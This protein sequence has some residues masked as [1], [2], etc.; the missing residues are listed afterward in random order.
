[1][2]NGICRYHVFGLIIN[3]SGSY[4]AIEP[5]WRNFHA[6][7]ILYP[8]VLTPVAHSDRHFFLDGLK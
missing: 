8:L 4:V 1:M 6:A 5:V 7:L 2:G 3:S